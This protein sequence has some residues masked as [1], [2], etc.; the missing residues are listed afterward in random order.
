MADA[1]RDL[2]GRLPEL[3][4][5]SFV[6][7]F[8]PE[9]SATPAVDP[10]GWEFQ[11]QIGSFH[12][13]FH[14]DDDETVDWDWLQQRAMAAY[15]DWICGE[16]PAVDLRPGDHLHMRVSEHMYPRGTRDIRWLDVTTMGDHQRRVRPYFPVEE[17]RGP[18]DP[19]DIPDVTDRDRAR[20]SRAL[21]TTPTEDED[22]GGGIS[23]EELVEMIGEATKEWE[24]VK[25]E[26]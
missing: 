13:S 1:L 26:W 23:A 20:W 25:E 16:I 22:S 12:W 3:M 15:M 24:E 5:V 4:L 10:Q 11:C 17:E 9:W 19:E 8:E 6:E 18:V 2:V 7:A 21:D 14:W